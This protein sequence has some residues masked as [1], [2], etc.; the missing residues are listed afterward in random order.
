MRLT[1][2]TDYALRLMIQLASE[3]SGRRTT[4]AQASHSL[5]LPLNHLTKI[6]HRLSKAR[7]LTTSQGR[8]G[9]LV[10]SRPASEITIGQVLRVTEPDFALVACMAGTDCSLRIGCGLKHVLDAALAAFLGVVDQ[11]T[12]AELTQQPAG[13]FGS[14]TV[15]ACEPP[16]SSHGSRLKH[17]SG[18]G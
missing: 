1:L 5:G 16:G 18:E 3:P 7:L 6:A 8:N 14:P 15:A 11:T 4:I 13:H 2:F 10:L 12:L 17:R 9:G